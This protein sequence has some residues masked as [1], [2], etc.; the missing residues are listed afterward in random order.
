MNIYGNLFRPISVGNLLVANRL[1]MP[2]MGSGLAN[3]N[4]EV[5][6]ELIAHY[7]RRAQGGV[8]ILIVEISCV[9][10]PVGRAGLNQIRIDH[11]R[12]LSGL[13]NLADHIKAGGARAF[14]Q[15]HHAGRQT[16]LQITE[17]TVPE[18]PSPIA[19]RLMRIVPREMNL[20]DINRVKEK[21]INSA[22]LAKR[23][24]FDGIELHAAHG[25]LLSE[26]LSPYANHRNDEYGG[27]P[28]R[29]FRLVKEIIA[30]IKQTCGDYPLSVRFNMADFVRGGLEP[31][32]GAQIARWLDEAG[33]H[34][35]NVSCGNYE[36]GMTNTEP[37][38]YAEGWRL[39]LAKAARQQVKQAM[40]MAG[41]TIR[42]PE[43]ADEI[44]RSGTADLVWLGRPLLADPNWPRKVLS[45]QEKDN[46][47]FLSCNIRMQQQLSGL[48][49]R[50]SVNPQVGRDAWTE[51]PLHS[52]KKILVIGAGP[53]GLQA[54]LSLSK[55]GHEV[56]IAEQ[57]QTLGGLLAAAATPPHKQK[58]DAFKEYLIKQVKDAQIELRT[59]TPLSSELI[60]S[61]APEAIVLAWGALPFRPPVPGSQIGID[62]S[63]LLT[64]G[65]AAQG[66]KAVVIGGAASGLEAA[67]FLVAAGRKVTVVEASSRLGQGLETMTLLTMMG[68]LKKAGVTMHLNAAVTQVEQGEI[69]L[70]N[71]DGIVSALGFDHLVWATGFRPRPLPPELNDYPGQL[72]TIGDAARGGD[73]LTGIAQADWSKYQL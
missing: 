29:R 34:I 17:G 4:G 30:G 11:P 26:F 39:Y 52:P 14:I 12:Y 38:S 60:K 46:R 51:P 48:P 33:V 43:T 5:T 58:I 16:S 40:I 2:A 23:A 31:E 21:F 7:E 50:C 67:A 73:L 8:G 32:E 25:Y 22:L 6:P 64:Q 59:N 61:I 65:I 69:M 10:A 24:G 42:N 70:E 15:L 9:D 45:R 62:V 66:T 53:T 3:S 28:I 56:I 54:A 1:V 18:A 44:I 27:D 57:G 55:K 36:S 72:I 68:E 19:C 35:L 49:L 71:K 13:T 47:P 41:G 63:T 20:D 37:A